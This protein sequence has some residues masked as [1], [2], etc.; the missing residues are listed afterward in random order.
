MRTRAASALRVFLGLSLDAHER[1]SGLLH[2]NDASGLAVHVEHVVREA[3]T[4]FELKLADRDAAM[5]RDV[6]L[7]R[8]VADD[9]AGLRE[10]VI[11]LF[12]GGLLG[13]GHLTGSWT[14]PQRGNPSGMI[15]AR[16]RPYR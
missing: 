1:R 14:L 4:W 3:V 15:P 7:D 12:A 10:Q 8:R 5:A 2:L 6:R 11:D 13:L 16:H 9:P